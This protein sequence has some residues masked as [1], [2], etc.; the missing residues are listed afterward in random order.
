[1]IIYFTTGALALSRD[2]H[3]PVVGEARSFWCLRS[4]CSTHFIEDELHLP[5]H[6]A[7]LHR[8]GLSPISDISVCDAASFGAGRV[9]EV[10]DDASYVGIGHDRGYSYLSDTANGLGDHHL[11]FIGKPAD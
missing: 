2:R 5:C 6:P 3:D 10:A 9:N 8:K 7:C 4:G 11:S 1:M